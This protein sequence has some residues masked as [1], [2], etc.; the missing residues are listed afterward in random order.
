MEPENTGSRKPR[1]VPKL[2]TLMKLWINVL[3][4]KNDD[5][6]PLFSTDTMIDFSFSDPKPEWP[7]NVLNWSHHRRRRRFG[8]LRQSPGRTRTADSWRS[9]TDLRVR[10]QMKPF[11]FASWAWPCGAE[12]NSVYFFY[13]ILIRKK[14]KVLAL[15]INDVTPFE[16][17][18][19]KSWEFD[20]VYSF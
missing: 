13:P 12:D 11:L 3:I 1:S 9:E 17:F 20:K 6:L 14:L 7:R 16:Y 19:S 8:D 10:P 5:N 18:L 4:F 15:P 2:H